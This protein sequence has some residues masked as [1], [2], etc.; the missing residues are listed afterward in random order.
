MENYI[1]IKKAKSSDCWSFFLAWIF[2]KEVFIH[3]DRV[4][5][6]SLEQFN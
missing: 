5:M 4:D 2:G 3:K 1:T 6:Y